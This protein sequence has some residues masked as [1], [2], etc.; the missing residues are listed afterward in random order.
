LISNFRR[1]VNYF[2]LLG[3]SPGLNLMFRRFGSWCGQE[4]TTCEG[5]TDRASQNVSTSNSDV[6]GNHPKEKN[7]IVIFCF[8]YLGT[9][10][11]L[12][13]IKPAYETTLLLVSKMCYSVIKQ[14]G[15]TTANTV[16]G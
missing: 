1:V 6:G 15:K 8:N 13:C 7:T 9:V 12:P 10:A 4:D 3:D 5:G 16:R 11:V 14:T 2:F